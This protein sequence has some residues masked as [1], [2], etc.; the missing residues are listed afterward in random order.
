MIFSSVA[1]NRDA[2]ATIGKELFA[3]E[4]DKH[5]DL[6]RKV[7]VGWPEQVELGGGID[8]GIEHRAQPAI[9]KRI[10]GEEIRHATDAHAAD[11]GAAKG[12]HV[13]AGQHRAGSDFRMV[14]GEAERPGLQFS[15]IRKSEADA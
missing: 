4:I 5:A 3:E 1:C 15:G 14:G 12:F 6:G 11:C 2:L 13:V 7:P 9:C 10:A 8:M